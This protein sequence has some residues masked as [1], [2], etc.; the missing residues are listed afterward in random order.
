MVIR[1]KKVVLN[2]YQALD[3]VIEMLIEIGKNIRE[4]GHPFPTAVNNAN[5][6]GGSAGLDENLESPII[7]GD[8]HG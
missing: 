8:S 3:D 1:S 4:T 5:P 2:K 6:T 7:Q